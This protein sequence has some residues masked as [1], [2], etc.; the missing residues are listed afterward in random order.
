MT[1]KKYVK[2]IGMKFLVLHYE[3]LADKTLADREKTVQLKQLSQLS[4]RGIANW[5]VPAFNNLLS[6]KGGLHDSLILIKNSK[7]I[8][9]T[10]SLKAGQIA[11]T[12]D[13]NLN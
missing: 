4:E 12:L 6:I 2:T 5:R 8:S 7:G 13:T 11:Q 1:I 10:I 9:K 3:T